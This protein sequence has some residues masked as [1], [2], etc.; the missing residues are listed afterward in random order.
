MPETKPAA[1]VEEMVQR[2]H[3]HYGV[4]VAYV[5]DDGEMMA[6]GHHEPRRVVAAFNREARVH[7]WLTNMCDDDRAWYRDVADDLR[8]EYGVLATACEGADQPD[9]D[10]DCG[11]CYEIRKSDWY[12]RWGEAD[13]PGAFPVTTWMP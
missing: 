13:T 6:L 12:V 9:H 4:R 10:D 3:E 2:M 5:G 11:E 7:S 8:Q 1:T